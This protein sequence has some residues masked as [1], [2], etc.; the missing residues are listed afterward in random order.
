[1]DESAPQESKDQSSLP[2][3]TIG[4][5]SR[6]D[7]ISL[8]HQLLEM[9]LI[10]HDQLEIANKE[11]LVGEG[12][13]TLAQTL[14]S[15]GFISESALS[16]A[17]AKASGVENV[18]IRNSLIDTNLLKILPKEVALRC[19]MIPL[20]QQDD[21]VTVALSDVYNILAIDQARRYFSNYK[22]VPVYA[23]EG[24]ILEIIDKYYRFETSIDGIIR[25]IEATGEGKEKLVLA[26]GAGTYTNPT[27]R[28]VDALLIDAI[29]REASDIH[30]EP[31]GAFLRIRYRIDG[32]LRQ[33]RSIHKDYWSAVAVRIK[34][35]SSMNIA[36]TRLPQDGRI[37]YSMLGRDIDFRA[38]TQPT[39]HGENIVLRIL[40]KKRSLVPLEKL[41][42]SDEN[43]KLLKKLLKRPEGIVI[44]TGPTGSGKT[45]TLYSILN[46]INSIDKNIMTLEDPVEYQIPLLRQTNVMESIGMDFYAGIRSLMRQDPDVIFIG[47]IRDQATANMAVRAAMTGHQVY[48]T[49]H[50][51]NA[52]GAIPRLMDIGVPHHLLAGSLI[53]LLAQ[54]LG[55]KLCLKCKEA[56]VATEEECRI[57]RVDPSNPPTIYRPKGCVS[58]EET[59]YRG[60]IALSEVLQVDDGM[61][62]LIDSQA[63][64]KDMLDYINQRGFV[65]MPLDGINKVLAGVT[66]I[67]EIIRVVD[68]TDYL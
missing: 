11:Q 68:M 38:A 50:T 43:V 19:K 53:C 62:N 12:E 28:L 33:I 1:M 24:E 47:E 3:A 6:K 26:E 64:R 45:T 15:M 46:Y 4:A 31:E 25:E 54:R 35:M 39:V 5:R 13:R 59:G 29:K 44:I 52:L 32:Q 8:G 10:S 51:N 66:A 57:L 20:S 16:T 41:G 14:V 27:V 30:F 40:D 23:P 36:E 63:S 61:D 2:Q 7:R 18:D 17:I 60:R 58:C 22:V 56:V 48:S 21:S 65:S 9:G 67:E 34:I 55:R 37:S 49:L 42:Y